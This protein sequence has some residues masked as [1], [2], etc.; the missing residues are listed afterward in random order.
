M[1]HNYI[2]KPVSR[3]DGPKK[4]KGE[5]QYA[6]EFSSPDLSYGVV[7]TAAITK[8]KIK[9]INTERAMAVE[10]MIEVFSHENRPHVAW[11]NRNYKDQDAPKGEHF[12]ALYDNVIFFSGQPIALCVAETF[13]AARFAASLLE[14]EYEKEDHNVDLKAALK[15]KYDPGAGKDGFEKPKS[16]GDAQTAYTTA[17]ARIDSDYSQPAHHHN[18]MEMHASTVIYD[19]NEDSYTVYDKTQGTQNSLDYVSKVFGVSDKKIRICAPFIGGAFGSGLR[20]QYQ[21]YLAFLAAK[22]LQ[23]SVRVVLTRQQMFTFGHRPETFQH[24]AMATDSSGQLQ[25]MKHEAVAET[26]TFENYVENVVNWTGIGYQ[27]DN[28]ELKYEVAQLDLYTP[29]DMRAPGATT[30]VFALECAIDEMAYAASM[31]PLQ[32]RLLNYADTD[33]MHKME[34]SSKALKEA[35]AQG[36]EKF[37]W[38]KRKPEP[39]SMRD[40]HLRVGWG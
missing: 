37:G 18:P 29:L 7:V 13:E 33:Q 20:P 9:S 19:K 27:C 34:Y 28:V 30:G 25:A 23:R 22:S 12:R 4:V 21:L 39:G 5:A 40:G 10:G 11:F 38:S 3:V 36:A 1:N 26:S 35:Y 8:G 16:R 6:A 24:V 32:F 14:I 31:D 15:D 17:A 2:G